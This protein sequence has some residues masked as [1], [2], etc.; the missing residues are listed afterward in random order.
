VALNEQVIKASI[1]QAAAKR[2]RLEIT[3]TTYAGLRVRIT[4]GTA[5]LVLGCRDKEGR[6]RRYPVGP[7]PDTGVAAARDAAR[8]LRADVAKG[9]DPIFEA[10]QKRATARLAAEGIGS[11]AGVLG[12]YE[13]SRGRTLKFWAD[14]KRRIESVFGR[15]LKRPLRCLGSNKRQRSDPKYDARR[16]CQTCCATGL[17][18]NFRP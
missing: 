10:R 9:A 11:L 6:A 5:T 1:K 15:Q 8:L 12:L 16:F 14:C 18:I 4:T 3:D 7:W 13:A 2:Q 17:W